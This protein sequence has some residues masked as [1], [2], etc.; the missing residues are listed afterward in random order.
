M[1]TKLQLLYIQVIYTATKF[2]CCTNANKKKCCL[3]MYIFIVY[4]KGFCY[5]M[6]S[7]F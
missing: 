1:Y 6:L 3:L 2:A 7:Q 5:K 4:K